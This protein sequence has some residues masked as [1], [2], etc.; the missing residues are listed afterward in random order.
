MYK[1][2]LAGPEVFARNA[3]VLA[4]EH[5][6]LCRQFGFHPLHPIDQPTLTSGFIYRTNIELLNAAHAVVANLNPFRGAEVDT[7]TAFEVGFAIALGKP[8]V[9]YVHDAETLKDRVARMHGKLELDH[10]V[11]RDRDGNLVEDF[12]HCLNL[13][14]SESCIIVVGGLEDA[15]KK[16]SSLDQ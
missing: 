10:G 7:G 8:V 16:L 14:L 11:W 2:Y 15:L 13:M 4:E 1:V 5:K 6:A 3:E 12:G 9:G